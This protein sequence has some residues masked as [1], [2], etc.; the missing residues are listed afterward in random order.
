MTGPAP[1]A[2]GTKARRAAFFDRDGV[3]N[4]DREYV[5]RIEDFEWMPGAAQAIRVCNDTGYLVFIVTNQ[6]GIARGLY[7]EA[8]V[9]A[10]HAHMLTEL[11]PLEA[12]VD[13]FRYCPH[14]P[15][16]RIVRYRQACRCRKPAPGMLL[17]LIAEYGVDPAGSFFVGDK[18]T[19]MAAARAAGV[20]G[21]L[22]RSGAVDALVSR[23][24]SGAE[25][26]PEA[27]R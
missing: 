18:E 27:P 8:A 14:H 26:A 1:L 25:Q 16:A 2:D 9:Q 4:V 5:A 22:Y 17:D 3:L 20:P 7:D 6:S 13:A 12:H 15:E 19:D 10:L 24:L 21:F 23:I 11:A